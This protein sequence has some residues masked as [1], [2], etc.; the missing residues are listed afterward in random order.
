MRT[1]ET[2]SVPTVALLTLAFAAIDVAS[3]HED[4]K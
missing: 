1:I 3:L 4:G 2:R